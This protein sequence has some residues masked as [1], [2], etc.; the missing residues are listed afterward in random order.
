MN[1]FLRSVIRTGVPAAVGALVAWLTRHGV[2]ADDTTVTLGIAWV[3]GVGYYG[4]ARTVETLAKSKRWGWLL[5]APG[6]L[7]YDPGDPA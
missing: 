5:G 4:L 1:D 7:S 3:S 2:K 6:G